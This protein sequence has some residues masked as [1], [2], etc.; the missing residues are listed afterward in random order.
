[1]QYPIDQRFFSDF[2][3]EFGR[4][5]KW[6]MALFLFDQMPFVGLQPTDKIFASVIKAVSKANQADT[7]LELLDRM[8]AQG[9]SPDAPTMGAVM[10]ACLARQREQPAVELY[11][12]LS[13]GPEGASTVIYNMLIS[14]YG[15]KGR[16]QEALQVCVLHVRGPIGLAATMWVPIGAQVPFLSPNDPPNPSQRR[17]EGFGKVNLSKIFRCH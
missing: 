15:R 11:Q 16:L 14:F 3:W 4:S 1:M 6:R 2:V 13:L 17:Q 5:R 8:L 9:H 10:K 7:A 12:R